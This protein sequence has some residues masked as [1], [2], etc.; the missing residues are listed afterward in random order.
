MGTTARFGF[1]YPAL[2]DAPNGPQLAQFLAED[3]EGW[4][5]RL[6][7]GGKPQLHP[8]PIFITNPLWS[9]SNASFR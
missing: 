3:T 6:D 4:L 9:T 5:S 1:R 2:T 8:L 7:G